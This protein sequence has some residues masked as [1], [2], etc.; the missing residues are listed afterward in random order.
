MNRRLLERGWLLS[1]NL[2]QKRKSIPVRKKVED[3]TET[4]LHLKPEFLED[5]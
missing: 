1:T 2:E 4:V 3:R 5:G